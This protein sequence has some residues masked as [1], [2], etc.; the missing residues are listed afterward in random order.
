MA[1]ENIQKHRPMKM[2][3]IYLIDYE[4]VGSD[5]LLCCDKLSAKDRIVIIF[6]KNDSKIDMT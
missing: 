2:R 3:T 1:Q 4:N 5:G 6:T